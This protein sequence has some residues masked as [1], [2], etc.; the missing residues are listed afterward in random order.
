[1][2]TSR[3][4]STGGALEP[5]TVDHGRDRGGLIHLRVGGGWDLVEGDEG[6]LD[7]GDVGFE[8]LKLL[9]ID[10]EVRGVG[11]LTHDEKPIDR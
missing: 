1:M 4:G 2:P 11:G 10:L 8:T 7:G 6:G 5:E 9:E 3:W